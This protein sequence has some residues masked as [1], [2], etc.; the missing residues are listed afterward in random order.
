MNCNRLQQHNFL[1]VRFST[2]YSF[3]VYTVEL[4]EVE[5]DNVRNYVSFRFRNE[6]EIAGDRLIL[7]W[8][9]VQSE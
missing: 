6:W 4:N 9:W 1:V 3:D 8:K 2:S 7:G 5:V